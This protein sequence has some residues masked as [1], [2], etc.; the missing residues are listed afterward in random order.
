MYWGLNLQLAVNQ[1]DDSTQG[2]V[3]EVPVSGD[4]V[5]ETILN[6][7]LTAINMKRNLLNLRL[8]DLGAC[9]MT[10]V[11][12]KSL[13]KLISAN[14]G[15][16]SL[17]LTGNKGVDS[18]GWRSLSESLSLNCQLDTLELHHNGL[19]NNGLSVLFDALSRNNTVA[20]IDLEGNHISDEEARSLVEL[21]QTADNICNVHVRAGN[22]ISEPIVEEIEKLCQSHCLPG[23]D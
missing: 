22:N 8:L 9:G 12:A 17:S 6:N 1:I 16:T 4:N 14:V 15:L 18:E 2:I 5:S 13:A 3:D 7:E 21:L 10:S 23:Q 19:S 20:T 11:G